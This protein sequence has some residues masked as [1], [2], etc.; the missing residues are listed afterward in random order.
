M[1]GKIIDVLKNGSIVL[2]KLLLNNYKKLNI[3]DQEF[4]LLI[5]LINDNEF[6]PEKISLGLDIKVPKILDLINDLSKKDI[7]KL[8]TVKNNNLCEEVICL[9]ELYNKLALLLTQNKEESKEI[10]IF[11]K[12]E[13]EFGRTLSPTEYEIITAWTDDHTED[14]ILLALKEA[15]YNGVSNLRY[16]DKILYEWQKKGI[17]NKEDYETQAQNKK[18]K[19][20][21]KEVFDYDWLNE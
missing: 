8:K 5:Y 13:N 9:D 16:I 19:E 20:T 21:T 17:K 4:I 15:V 3:T 12:F 11:D 18:Q 10:T 14:I 6:D 1:T 2:P 7:L